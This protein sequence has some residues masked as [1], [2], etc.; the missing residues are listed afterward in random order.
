MWG[1]GRPGWHIECSALALRELGTT[2]DLHGGG[3]DLIFPHHECERAQSEAATGEPFV[4]HWMHT[5][6]IAKDGEKMSKSLGNLVF[7]DALRKEWDPMAIRLA[8][9]E[10]H[11]RTEWEWDDELMPRVGR[12]AR[13]VAASGRAGA[14]ATCSPTSAP[15]STT[16]S[17]PRRRWPRS[18]PLQPAA[19]TS[20]RRPTCSACCS[21]ARRSP[22]ADLTRDL[23]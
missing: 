19:T 9:I 22:T 21:D 6:L 3:T 7:V 14:R 11:Y 8:V 12:A 23:P 1:P 15:P 13:R 4:R 10:H 5:A 16:I 20:A 17:T 18:T 2:I